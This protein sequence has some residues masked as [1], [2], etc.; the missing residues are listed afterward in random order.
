MDTVYGLGR[1][2]FYSGVAG[3]TIFSGISLFVKPAFPLL[4]IPFDSF[5]SDV[6]GGLVAD[7]VADDLGVEVA[8]FINRSFPLLVSPFKSSLS[9]VSA[10]LVADGVADDLGVEVAGTAMADFFAYEHR[11][12][13]S[14]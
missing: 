8:R 13:S 11:D 12:L 7:G 2:F 10:D 1:M 6:S 5:L 4:V 3:A 14:W 9:D